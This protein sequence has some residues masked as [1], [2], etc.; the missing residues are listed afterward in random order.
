MRLQL[1]KILFKWLLV[2]APSEGRVRPYVKFNITEIKKREA[3][4]SLSCRSSDQ[5]I[6]RS[7]PSPDILSELVHHGPHSIAGTK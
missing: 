4:T 3:E 5:R 6:W 7:S 2:L 1:R